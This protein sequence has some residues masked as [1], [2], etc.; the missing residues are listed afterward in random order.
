[1]TSSCSGEAMRLHVSV[2]QSRRCLGGVQRG[3][4]IVESIR[5]NHASEEGRGINLL[6]GADAVAPVGDCAFHHN[7]IWIRAA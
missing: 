2:M 1:M 4:V 5:P 7:R 6:T 3:V